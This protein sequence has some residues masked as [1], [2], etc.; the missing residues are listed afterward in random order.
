MHL[1]QLNA[2]IPTDFTLRSEDE[3]SVVSTDPSVDYSKTFPSLIVEKPMV[4]LWHK[5]DRVFKV[6]VIGHALNSSCLVLTYKLFVP[7]K[8]S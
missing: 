2:F 8:G 3:E 4:R 6:K 7:P 1:P 5:M